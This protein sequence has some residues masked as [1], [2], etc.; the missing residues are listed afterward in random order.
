MKIV[1]VKNKFLRTNGF[2]NW[3]L[4]AFSIS[5]TKRSGWNS[6]NSGSF[7]FWLKTIGSALLKNK[8]QSKINQ[9]HDSINPILKR[10]NPIFYKFKSCLLPLGFTKFGGGGGGRCATHCR[11]ICNN[12]CAFSHNSIFY[13]NSVLNV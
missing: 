6:I 1:E 9:Q 7:Y 12:L 8:L 5:T 2:L 4:S 3:F 13:T 11:G 10:R